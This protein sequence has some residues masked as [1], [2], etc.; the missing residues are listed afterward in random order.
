MLCRVRLEGWNRSPDGFGARFDLTDA[1][2]W[3]RTWFRTPLVDVDQRPLVEA[4]PGAGPCRGELPARL[5]RPGGDLLDAAD[6]DAQGDA[7]AGG[8]GQNTADLC[9]SS[10][11]GQGFGR[12]TRPRPP[13]WPA[14]WRP[15]R[16]RPSRSPARPWWRRRT[17][18]EPR[19]RLAGAGGGP[20]LGQVELRGNS[21]S[22]PTSRADPPPRLQPRE[23]AGD[24]ADQILEHQPPPVRVLAG[25]HGH[26]TI[27]AYRHIQR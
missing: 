9:D 24:T 25:L 22:N 11:A 3:L 14:L 19:P 10:S 16:G 7:V 4:R 2:C 1:P 27:F 26:R 15:A 5:R 17:R 12:D 18:R 23:P 6:A 8:D 21:A 20:D 13:C